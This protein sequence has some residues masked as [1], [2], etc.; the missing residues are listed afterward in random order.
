M[1]QNEI[2]NHTGYQFQM[3]GYEGACFGQMYLHN[4]EKPL[5]L[6]IVDLFLHKKQF[7]DKYIEKRFETKD[8]LIISVKLLSRKYHYA[9]SILCVT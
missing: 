7:I 4:F 5:P 1:V 9:M 2:D 6:S 3:F 8:H